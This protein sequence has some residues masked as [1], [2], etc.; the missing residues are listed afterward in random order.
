MFAD[1]AAMQNYAL[2]PNRSKPQRDQWESDLE[3]AME[4]IGGSYYT[5]TFCKYWHANS[6]GFDEWLFLIQG[7]QAR[8]KMWGFCEGQSSLAMFMKSILFLLFFAL[9]VF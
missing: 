8:Q 6:H 9:E 3:Q 4:D 7:S 2:N 1:A 5:T